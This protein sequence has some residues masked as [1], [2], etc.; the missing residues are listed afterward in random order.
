MTQVGL[1]SSLV[2]ELEI[3]KPMQRP[4]QGILNEIVGIQVAAGF[5]RQ[6]AGGPAVQTRQVALAEAIERL[7][8]TCLN[9]L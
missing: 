2:T 5:L 6:A 4:D 9:A 7:A 1:E 3:W 8:V